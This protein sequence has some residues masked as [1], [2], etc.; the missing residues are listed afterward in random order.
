MARAH[1]RQSP[2]LLLS[3]FPTP[4][5]VS[6]LNTIK[7]HLA[8]FFTWNQRNPRERRS[9]R[10]RKKIR[11]KLSL[12][13]SWREKE[14]GE[15]EG[16][17]Q[18]ENTAQNLTPKRKEEEE[19]VTLRIQEENP[20]VIISSKND[21]HLLLS[22]PLFF[23]ARGKRGNPLTVVNAH[24]PLDEIDVNPSRGKNGKFLHTHK[25]EIYKTF[26]FP[27]VMSSLLTI[28][29]ITFYYFIIILL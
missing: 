20:K 9:W 18:E 26:P 14:K 1:K 16:K 11:F 5:F 7:Y 22:F 15:D 28:R 29:L 23:I 10:R 12:L 3:W 19:E 8:C 21:K 6:F 2:R 17:E 25:Y 13:E 4:S 24:L 27:Y